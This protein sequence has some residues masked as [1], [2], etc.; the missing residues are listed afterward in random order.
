MY[1]ALK[2]ALA[3]GLIIIADGTRTVM[4]DRPIAGFVQICAGGETMN[5]NSN[6]FLDFAEALGVKP[7]FAQMQRAIELRIDLAAAA[8]S[9]HHNEHSQID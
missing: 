8:S 3:H 6:D 2:Y 9:S 7:S 4:T 5:S 1:E